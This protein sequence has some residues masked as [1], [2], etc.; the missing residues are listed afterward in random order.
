MASK[1]RRK[2]RRC[3]V[4]RRVKRV[5]DKCSDAQKV[6]SFASILRAL[7]KR[8]LARPLALCTSECPYIQALLSKSLAKRMS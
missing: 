1:C 7:A 6:L 3:L 2:S 8:G 5:S 4:L